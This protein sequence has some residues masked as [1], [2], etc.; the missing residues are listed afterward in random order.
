MSVKR[1]QHGR[2]SADFERGAVFEHP[3]DVTVDEGAA[4]LFSASFADATP[5]YASNAF[6]R[7]LSFRSRPIHPLLLFQYALSFSV[8]DVSEQCIAHLAFDEVRWPNACYPGETLRA[9]SKVLDVRDAKA[10]RAVVSVRTVL[11][12]DG[13]VVCTFTRKV[14]VP[15]GRNTRRP[16]APWPHVDREIGEVARLPEAL[17]DRVVLPERRGG[18]SGFFDDFSVGDVI[19]HPVGRTVEGAEAQQLATLTRNTHPL[20]TDETWAREHGFGKTRV[21]DGGLVFAWAVTLSSRETSGNALWDAG[22]DAG[23]HPGP[24]VAGDTLYATSKV[25]DVHEHDERTGM[26]TFRIVGTRNVD[27]GTLLDRGADL[28]TPE[29]EKEAAARVPEKVVELSRTV[30]MRRRPGRISLGG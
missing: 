30:L 18:F 8:Q 17:R 25:V 15:Q 2:F 28:F 20:H 26:V 14:L 10:E 24:L 16:Q 22:V 21:V 19:V 27:G 7:A 3:W 29:L 5:T 13:H 6:A 1:P 23:A 12:G 11:E 4:T 9:W